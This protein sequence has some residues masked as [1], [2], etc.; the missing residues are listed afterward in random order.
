MPWF[1]QTLKCLCPFCSKEGGTVEPEKIDQGNF[2]VTV[3]ASENDWE[4]IIHPDTMTRAQYFDLHRITWLTWQQRLG[5]ALVFDAI[6]CITRPCS[7]KDRARRRQ[8]IDALAWL[9]GNS[10]CQISFEFAC[11]LLSSSLDP[12]AYAKRIFASIRRSLASQVALPRA[13]KVVA[14]SESTR[15]LAGVVARRQSELNAS[16]VR[17]ILRRS[18]VKPRAAGRA[19]LPVPLSPDGKRSYQGTFRHKVEAIIKRDEPE[20]VV[21]AAAG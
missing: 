1:G 12:K 17:K 3:P 21:P 8:R 14:M 20:P 19:P 6:H 2:K 4:E 9:A 18:P 10:D 11:A 5:Y 13:H 16:V 7:A 15:Y